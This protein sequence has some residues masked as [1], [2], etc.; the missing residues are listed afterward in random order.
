MRPQAETELARESYRSYRPSYI[1]LLYIITK[2]QGPRRFRV[3]V[4]TWKRNRTCWVYEL[5]DSEI[6]K[7]LSGK[8]LKRPITSHIDVLKT[9]ASSKSLVKIHLSFTNVMFPNI[10]SLGSIFPLKV[11]T[12]SNLSELSVW[13][14]GVFKI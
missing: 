13:I 3:F 6:Y 14:L 2:A 11:H 10:N 8:K 9:L 7:S 12:K 4:F 1:I 5:F